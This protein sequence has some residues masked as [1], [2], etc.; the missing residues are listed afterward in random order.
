MK[1]IYSIILALFLCT[2][3]SAAV[4]FGEN[5]QGETTMFGR[6][7]DNA[8]SSSRGITVPVS[9]PETEIYSYLTFFL[10]VLSG[11]SFVYFFNGE[12]NFKNRK[13]DVVVR[14]CILVCAFMFAASAV[15]SWQR[16]EDIIVAW[17]YV[18]P[19]EAA[20]AK[21]VDDEHT[22]QAIRDRAKAE[23]NM[24]LDSLLERHGIYSSSNPSNVT[25][26]NYSPVNIQTQTIYR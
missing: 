3:S 23:L 16:N 19:Q 13:E 12:G 14:Y 15:Y 5:S 20:F 24:D 9:E 18:H 7:N 2:T 8:V 25:N 22:V 17:K 21:I 1:K 4:W 11:L 26:I 10:G 6:D